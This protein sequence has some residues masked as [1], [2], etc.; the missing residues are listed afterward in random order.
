MTEKAFDYTE[1][2]TGIFIIK[3]TRPD[4]SLIKL[5]CYAYGQLG[6]SIF[7]DSYLLYD[8]IDFRNYT[9]LSNHLGISIDYKIEVKRGKFTHKYLKET[10]SPYFHTTHFKT[11]CGRFNARYDDNISI[12]SKNSF[13]MARVGK[14]CVGNVLLVKEGNIK[15]SDC[16]YNILVPKKYIRSF[17]AYFKSYEYRKWIKD[18]AH[19][20]CSFVITKGDVEKMLLNKIDDFNKLK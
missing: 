8:R 1:A 14:R 12:A 19:G 5:N 17:V 16:V 11:S 13:L 10:K 7:K 2:K 3:K 4:N 18:V 6:C 9:P 15:Y 20:I